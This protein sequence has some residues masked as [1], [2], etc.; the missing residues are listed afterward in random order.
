MKI[1]YSDKVPKAI[2]SVIIGM[3]TTFLVINSLSSLNT[4][5]AHHTSKKV[6]IQTSMMHDAEDASLQKSG[7]GILT[8]SPNEV[9]TIISTS[10]LVEGAYTV[11]WV[12]FNRP[13]NC[14]AKAAPDADV[15]CDAKD[16][17]NEDVAASVFYATG[18]VTT[19]GK[20]QFGASLRSGN[21]QR[22][23]EV[24]V[25]RGGIDGDNSVTPGLR[26]NNGLHAEIHLVLRSHGAVIE[27][28]LDEQTNSFNGGCDL[29]SV[30]P[31]PSVCKAVQEIAFP[32]VRD[33]SS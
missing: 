13:D 29:A 26:R 11:W 15:R 12:I 22:T 6:I 20:A 9:L 14:S 10:E 19:T 23:A 21:P 5:H 28:L 32:P 33:R 30:P 24:A 4:A 3:T 7:G 8:R 2:P 17:Y 27:S 25:G 16:V 18:F 31:G 1:H